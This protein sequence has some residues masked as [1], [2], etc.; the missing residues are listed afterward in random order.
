MAELTQRLTAAFDGR[1]RIE[2]QLGEGGMATVYLAE[3]VKHERKVALKILKPELAAVIGAERFIAEIKTTANLQHPHILTLFDSG[4]V[5]GFLYYVMPYIE[6]ETLRGKL[7]REKQLG[8]E[9]A[10]RIARDVADA[11]D[12]AH[13][14]DIIHRDIKPENIL[15]H[16]GRPVVADFGIALAISAAGGGR[17]T[18][19]GLSLGTPHYMSP[20]QASADRDLSTRSDL[21][22]LGC[23][24]YEMIAGQPPHTGP[25]A[26]SILMRILTETPRP[27]TELRHT[28]PPHVSAA[29]AKAIEKLPADRFD[30]AKS[31]MK[32]LEDPGFTYSP[33]IVERPSATTAVRSPVAPA[34]ASRRRLSLMIGATAVV[35]LAAGYLLATGLRPEAPAGVSAAFEILPDTSHLV[36][37]FCCGPVVAVSPQGDR[38]VYEGALGEQQQSGTQALYQRPLGERVALRVPGTGN[39]R[40]PFFS[41]DGQWLGF[42]KTDGLYKVRFDGGSPLPVTSFAAL[43]AGA[44][45]GPDNTIVYANRGE[46]GLFR[47]PADGG[48][49]ERVTTVDTT[50]GEVSHAF[51]HFLPDGETVLFGVRGRGDHF[52]LEAV[53][54]KTGQ[55]V[56]LG[57]AGSDP[58]YVEPGFLV[59]SDGSG[60]I[61]AQPFDAGALEVRGDRFRIA[62]GVQ[63]RNSGMSEFGISRTGTLIFRETGGTGNEVRD[64]I[65]VDRSGREE[66]VTSGPVLRGPRFSPD[67]RYIAYAI[68]AGDVDEV[69]R[70][71][72]LR[73]NANRV[74]FEGS[75]R[76]VSW[77]PDGDRLLFQREGQGAV[78]KDPDGSGAVES[79]IQ[80]EGGTPVLSPDGRWLLWSIGEG[81]GLR[82][83]YKSVDEG[84]EERPLFSSRFPEF[85]PTISPDGRW[86]AYVA[87]DDG[88]D[89]IYVSPFPDLGARV[90]ISPQGGRGPVWSRDGTELFYRDY[91][92]QMLMAVEVRAE[93]AFDVGTYTELFQESGYRRINGGTAYDVGPDGQRFVFVRGGGTGG[94]VKTVVVTN[95][96]NR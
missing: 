67:G 87:E 31:F 5:E 23:V 26:Q 25:S 55:R 15:L 56:P 43:S 45:W 37:S 84:G 18:E 96:L 7:D 91:A 40:S 17:M 82:I 71:D 35:A 1:Y 53:R 11:L 50:A 39:A 72:L 13:R 47:V 92:R 38:I 20:E 48:T 51:P 3:D 89:Q 58:S 74:T 66:V 64:V 94:G 77:S 73:S 57:I 21:Y 93:E 4:E 52:A 79:V 70:W 29:V 8:V 65:M 83:W 44:T 24:L 9:E 60:S 30:G 10:V 28:V 32:A 22:S 12:Y 80:N 14:S 88:E 49:A 54:L 76:S 63:F 78:S 2:R 27:L 36:V 6:G 90:K 69:W 75:S 34:A 86:I 46:T 33:T 59:F 19:T 68:D 62:D 42:F 16:D 81:L 41:P 95:A 61:M 85:S